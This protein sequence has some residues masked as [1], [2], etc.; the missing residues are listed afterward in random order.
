MLLPNGAA[1]KLDVI[2]SFKKACGNSEN[3][4]KDGSM[5]WNFVDA[6]MNLDLGGVYSSDYLYECFNVLATNEEWV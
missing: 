6:D 2:E 3:W 5:N 4:N 1:I